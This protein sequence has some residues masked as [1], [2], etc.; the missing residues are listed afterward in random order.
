[1]MPVMDGLEFTRKLKADIRTCHIPLILLTAR[2]SQ[3]QKIEGLE[4]GA[5]SY[6]AKPFNKK[7]L[8]V[9]VS[10][11]IENRQKIRKHYQSDNLSQFVSDNKI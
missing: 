8:Q 7:H 5:D 11:L 9:R 2:S 6:I 1:M 3:D 10:R 4:T